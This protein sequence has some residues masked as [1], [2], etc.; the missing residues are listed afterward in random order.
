MRT[1]SNLSK[2]GRLVSV[3]SVTML[4]SGCTG[5][6]KG[7]A[8]AILEKSETEDTRQCQVWGQPFTGLEP[9]LVK[10]QGKTKVLFVHGVGDHIPGYTTQFLEKLAKDLNLNA[11]SEGQKNIKLSAP[12]VPDT[13]LG[14]LRVT[15]LLNEE[16]GKDLTFYELT[17]SD[18][19]RKQKE[20]LAFDNSGE[21]DF[22][23]AKINGLLKK[24]SNDTGPDPI[25]YLGQS[26]D[27]ILAAFGQS[28]CWMASRDY[29]DIPSSGTHA[30][31]GLND[32]NIDHIANDD[33]VFISHSLGSRITIDGLQRIAHILANVA[34]YSDP[35]KDVIITDKVIAAF[36][37]KRIPIYML[38]NQLPMLQLGRELP[39]VVGDR[40]DYCDAKGANYNKR[41]V[42][43]TEI[44]AFSDPN[45]LLSYGI[46]PGFAQQY[47]DAR[48]C[49][50]VTNVNINIAN[51]MDAFGFA[52]LA[53]PM[54]AHIGYDSDDRVVALIAK[55]IGH[56]EDDPLVKQRCQFTKEVK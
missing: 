11:R 56:P 22:R 33:Y 19:T 31:T 34:K 14:N 48:M 54:Q 46:P 21:Y 26:R 27:A 28:V 51:V 53:N 18:I 50:T 17:W 55:G 5:I 52:D 30:C 40:A 49:T 32:S 39:E 7:I 38:S 25:I 41:M 24:F 4:L 8:E 12:L 43:Q 35:S 36:Q 6:G 10:K 1:C 9:G 20:L 37:N 13:E 15:H 45:D 47:L 23:R 29:E 3:L 2:T 42:N 44:I 16:T